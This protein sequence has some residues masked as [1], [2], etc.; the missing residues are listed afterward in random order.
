MSRGHRYDD[1]INNYTLDQFYGFYD[2]A[3]DN[4]ESELLDVMVFNRAAGFDEKSM[5]KFLRELKYQ[6]IKRKSLQ[7]KEIPVNVQGLERFMK[8]K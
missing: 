8:V 7:G 5:K 2:A 1:I 6:K 3:I 4:R